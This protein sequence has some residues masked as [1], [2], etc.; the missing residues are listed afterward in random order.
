MKITS[1]VHTPA[2]S[3]LAWSIAAAVSLSAGF[4]SVSYAADA[5]AELEEITVTGSRIQ[6]RDFVSP[7]PIT[8][9]DAEGLERLGINNIGDAIIQVPQ[10][11]S[12]FQP[13]NT[14]GSAFYIGSTLANLRGLNPFFGTRTLTLVDSHRFIPTTQGDAVDLNFIPS[15]LVARVES[16]TG[17]A[18]AAY[19]SG[20]IS[21]VVNIILDT[22][23]Q[24]VKLDA[25]YGVT[26]ESDG[27]NARFGIGAGTD[28]ADGRGHIVVGGEFQQ[29][30]VIQSCADSRDWCSEGTGL[31]NN[32]TPP[33]FGGANIPFTAN[34]PGQPHYM[35]VSGLRE[36]QLSRSGVIFNNTASATTTQQFDAAG[37][38]LTNFNIGQQG[39][40]GTGGLVMGGDGDRAYT[41]LTLQPDV[42]RKTFFSHVEYDFTDVFTGYAELS[43]G[44]VEGV[45]NQFGSGQNA[46]NNCVRPDNA[47]LLGMSAAV[48]AAVRAQDGN[49]PFS[50]NDNVI[51]STAFTFF[52]NG[53]AGTVISKKLAGPEPAGRYHGYRS[54]AWPRRPTRRYQ[55]LELGCV[56]PVWRNHA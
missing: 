12:Q 18:S 17:G 25:D 28:F 9:I 39:F 52:P 14:G 50:A 54:Y 35:I 11:V 33:F 20:A 34:I 1:A 26:Q 8:T 29:T 5:A 19:G 37:T 47:Y 31:Y 51:C 27:D 46:T 42:E 55:W 3:K 10:N 21:G 48:Q 7:N 24:G 15:N 43:Y 2:R 44:Q 49:A 41:N 23:L 40:R 32:A 45:N 6:R 53:V 22:R 38:G 16:V 56:L 4:T 13:N 30:D 36:N